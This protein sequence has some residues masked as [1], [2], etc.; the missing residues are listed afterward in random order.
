MLKKIADQPVKLEEALELQRKSLRVC[1]PRMRGSQ[2]FPF[3]QKLK[4][5]APKTRDQTPSLRSSV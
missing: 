3:V 1:A 4:G 2:R 5:P